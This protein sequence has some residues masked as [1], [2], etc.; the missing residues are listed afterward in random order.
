M[1]P[2]LPIIHAQ[3][4]KVGL[5]AYAAC[6]VHLLADFLKPEAQDKGASKLSAFLP[7]A[8]IGGR[9]EPHSVLPSRD[10]GTGPVADSAAVFA[11]A[12]T[13][14]VI[15]A[16]SR[17]GRVPHARGGE[18]E[19]GSGEEQ[20]PNSK[21]IV[22]ASAGAVTISPEK[23]FDAERA[24]RRMWT[25]ADW[26]HVHAVSGAVHTL[27]GLVY[28]LDLMIGDVVRLNGGAYTDHV[29]IEWVLGSMVFGA[30]N[31]ISGL[32]TSLLPRP[33][34]NPAQLLGFGEDG[35]LQ[36]AGFLNTAGFYFFLTYQSLRVLPE[37]PQWLVP[38]DPLFAAITFVA[39][40]HTIF[41]INSWVGR[42]KLSQGFAL[43]MSLPLLLNCPV[44]LHLFFQGQSWV[45]DL[46]A[47][48]PGWPEVFFSANYALAWAGSLV[49]LV[50][51][52]YERKVCNLTE[53]LLMTLFLGLITF[54]VIPL[55]AKLLIPQW[56]EGQWMV[57]LTLNPPSA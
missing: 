46:T 37:Y 48:Y 3:R 16:S 39:I 51:S 23:S 13:L 17:G 14:G 4:Y 18:A 45:Q 30:V 11:A 49:T 43:G 52:L 12:A 31:A 36:A 25:K 22:E 29:P 42:G 47:I 56:F 54:I 6:A 40:F 8:S 44:S 55:R 26:L 34:N 24:F 1:A 21:I 5:A 20:L 38:L 7:S 32:Q 53:R 9:L 27:I 57:M 10:A 28:L 35:N 33:F 19:I 50:L 2:R 41:I 15:A